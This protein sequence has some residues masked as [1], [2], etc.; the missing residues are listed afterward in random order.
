MPLRKAGK[1]ANKA[2]KA[3]ELN[4]PDSTITLG[5]EEAPAAPTTPPPAAPAPLESVYSLCPLLST[6]EHAAQEA[7][8][9][10]APLAPA[11][12]QTQENATEKDE[13]LFWTEEMMEMLVDGLY[14][15]FEKGGAADNSFKKATFEQ[16]AEKVRKAYNGSIRVTQQ[17]CKNKWADLNAKWSHLC[18]L[19]NSKR[20]KTY[21][22]VDFDT[23]K[24]ISVIHFVIEFVVEL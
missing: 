23:F 16:V 22:I 1:R 9:T 18:F 14:E 8:P 6:P 17:H 11:A 3:T 4:V 10:A 2:P 15:V 5:E 7:Q 12:Q 19:H 20:N 13:K 24:D 21:D